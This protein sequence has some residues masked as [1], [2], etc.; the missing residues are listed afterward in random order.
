MSNVSVVP[1]EEINIDV[2][3]ALQNRNTAVAGCFYSE[4]GAVRMSCER[5]LLR[6]DRA[7]FLV[8]ILTRI[9]YYPT[10]DLIIGL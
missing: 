8:V 2:Q 9:R 5:G 7:H 10:Q 1:S 3:E 6:E 4:N